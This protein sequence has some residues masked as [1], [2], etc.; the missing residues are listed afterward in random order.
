MNSN[1]A[2]NQPED[3]SRRE[4]TPILFGDPMSAV[5]PQG[6][7]YEIDT[8]GQRVWLISLSYIGLP[9]A[10]IGRAKIG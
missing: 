3:R 10:I 4:P 6:P 9:Q 1:R 2:L 7:I 8:A 5:S